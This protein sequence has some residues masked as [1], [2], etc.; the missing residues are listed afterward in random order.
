MTFKFHTV[1]PTFIFRISSFLCTI[2]S[3]GPGVLLSGQSPL[4]VRIFLIEFSYL[5]WQGRILITSLRVTEF[6]QVPVRSN[7]GDGRTAAGDW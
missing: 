7:Q 3:P 6:L 2:R 4:L 5:A 1:W